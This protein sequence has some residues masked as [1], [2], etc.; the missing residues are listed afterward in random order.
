MAEANVLFD[1]ACDRILERFKVENLK[2]LQRKALEKLLNGEDV[3]VMFVTCHDV[4]VIHF[5]L[6]LTLH[7]NVTA[8]VEQEV[9]VFTMFHYSQQ[10]IHHNMYVMT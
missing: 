2:D 9:P 5:T 1:I 7:D 4:F 10:R 8:C 3:F 6:L